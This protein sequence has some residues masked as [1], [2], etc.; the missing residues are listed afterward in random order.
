MNQPILIA[1]KTVYFLL[2]N[3]LSQKYRA[4]QG[5]VIKLAHAFRCLGVKIDPNLVLKTT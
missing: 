5:E 2:N 1:N 4:E 3:F